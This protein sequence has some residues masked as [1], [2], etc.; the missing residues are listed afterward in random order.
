MT[1]GAALLAPGSRQDREITPGID[2]IDTGPPSG[3]DGEIRVEHQMSSAIAGYAHRQIRRALAHAPEPVLCTQLRLT[4]HYD[5]AVTNPIVAQANITMSKP[6]R[7][8][9][10]ATTARDAIDVLAARLRTR[11]RHMTQRPAALWRH[12][13]ARPE[14]L[15]Y[16]RP[17]R[18]RT[19]VRN[20]VFEPTPQTCSEAATHVAMMDYSFH[21][22]IEPDAVGESLLYRCGDNGYRL[23]RIESAPGTRGALPVTIDPAPTPALDIENAIAR[24]ELSGSPFLFFRNR[25]LDRG[26]VLYHRYDGH[27]GLIAPPPRR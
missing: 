13:D 21:L 18:Q 15:L 23:A 25:A 17:V 22:F 1:F 4:A 7:V 24:L 19:I 8:Q 3:P 16:M 2:D 5:S 6:I 9:V 14:M 20:K 27:Y 26:C 12:C 11:L 10:A